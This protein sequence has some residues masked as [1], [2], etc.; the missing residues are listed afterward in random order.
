MATQFKV[1]KPASIF[2]PEVDGNEKYQDSGEPTNWVKGLTP[3]KAK[4][5]KVNCPI[6]G[7]DKKHVKLNAVRG[8]VRGVPNASP[9]HLHKL[10]DNYIPRKATGADN[11]Y[12]DDFVFGDYVRGDNYEGVIVGFNKSG[13]V[14]DNLDFDHRVIAYD[15]LEKVQRKKGAEKT[16]IAKNVTMTE[17]LAGPVTDLMRETSRQTL[18]EALVAAIGTPKN[19]EVEAPAPEEVV[20]KMELMS[21]KTYLEQEFNRWLYAAKHDSHAKK[22]DQSALRR[23]A[24]AFVAHSRNGQRI[25]NEFA[26]K[27]K[28]VYENGRLAMNAG[29]IVTLLRNARPDDLFSVMLKRNLTRVNY[30]VSGNMLSSIINDT[31]EEYIRRHGK[32]AQKVFERLFEEEVK[33]LHKKYKVK[34]SDRNTFARDHGKRVNKMY[35]DYVAERKA[36]RKD[37]YVE[38]EELVVVVNPKYQKVVDMVTKGVKANEKHVYAIAGSNAKEYLMRLMLP[39][40]FLDERTR[41]GVEAKFARAKAG[42]GQINVSKLYLLGLA[43]YMPEVSMSKTSKKN[44]ALLEEAI[45][46]TSLY[47]AKLAAVTYMLY[48]HP[49]AKFT[50]P[51]VDMFNNL[52]WDKLTVVPQKVCGKKAM[53]IPT[54]DLVICNDGKEFSCHTLKDLKADLKAGRKNPYTGREY[55]KEVHKKYGPKK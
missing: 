1:A 4:H 46:K 47:H 35:D 50:L 18:V 32:D 22:V 9:I 51:K 27:Y 12:N 13:A 55:P 6:K 36:D 17:V 15:L 2:K 34:K 33:N 54:K 8:T 23:A 20:R 44:L 43:Q 38:A 10:Y 16:R 42:S 29:Q 45:E 21:R 7:C 48:A 28:G 31:I 40:V 5:S 30:A 41:I 24:N 53:S 11:I 19:L 25:I 49:G 14:V 39:I 37:E 3:K 26:E 52:P